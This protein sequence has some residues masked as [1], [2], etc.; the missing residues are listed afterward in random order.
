MKHNC[1]YVDEDGLNYFLEAI[2]DGF[3][4]YDDWFDAYLVTYYK[5]KSFLFFFKKRW[6]MT[7]ILI[8]CPYCG[9][10]IYS[11]PKIKEE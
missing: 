1:K 10:K 2:V 11:E 7:D 8:Y 9:E 6:G 3:I 5:E 4:E